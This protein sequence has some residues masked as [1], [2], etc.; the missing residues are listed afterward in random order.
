VVNFNGLGS[1][2]PAVFRHDAK[3]VE[4]DASAQEGPY[5]YCDPIKYM[6]AAWE[7]RKQELQD[8]VL[9]YINAHQSGLAGEA[10]PAAAL[11]KQ[12]EIKDGQ[13]K[14]LKEEDHPECFGNPIPNQGPA[15]GGANVT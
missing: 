2:H 9:P 3:I 14:K 10:N 5:N 4:T 8:K 12:I 13:M 15:Q 1:I 11:N 7:I 6:A